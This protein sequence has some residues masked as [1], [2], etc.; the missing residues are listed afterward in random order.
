MGN[1][2]GGACNGAGRKRKHS[3]GELVV[4]AAFCPRT[5]SHLRALAE[6][7]LELPDDFP[8]DVAD[9]L[10]ELRLRYRAG[11][12]IQSAWLFREWALDRQRRMIDRAARRAG[13]A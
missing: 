6:G 1:G 12:E 9:G 2:W 13:R 10:E 4:S 8:T 7:E 5:T 11:G 3:L